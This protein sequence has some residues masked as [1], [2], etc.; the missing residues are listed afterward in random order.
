M[1]HQDHRNNHSTAAVDAVLVVVEEEVIED[2]DEE[3]LI[4]AVK[5][6]AEEARTTILNLTE[7]MHKVSRTATMHTRRRLVKRSI[8]YH[9]GPSTDPRVVYQHSLASP[10]TSLLHQHRHISSTDTRF[11]MARNHQQEV[12]S[13]SIRLRHILLPR[14]LLLS[15]PAHTSIPHSLTCNTHSQHHRHTSS[16]HSKHHQ[17]RT[18]LRGRL[19]LHNSSISNSRNNMRPNSSSNIN[20]LSQRLSLPLLQVISNLPS[21]HFRLT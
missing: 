8:P 11:N 17:L 6:V 13:I 9:R 5:E 21:N 1:D 4:L 16:T 19:S 3:G 20:I 10:R 7:A 15:H 2:V 14:L 12:H 18:I